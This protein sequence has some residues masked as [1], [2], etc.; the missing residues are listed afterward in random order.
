MGQEGAGPA[1]LAVHPSYTLTLMEGIVER[2]YQD[3][4][5][6]TRS[7]YTAKATYSLRFYREYFNPDKEVEVVKWRTRYRVN[8]EGAEFAINLDNVTRPQGLGSFIEI[9]AR[10]WSASDAEKKASLIS[11][12]LRELG[13]NPENGVRA[14]Y[15]HLAQQATL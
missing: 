3:S 2:E 15:V 1:G 13:L 7:R 11:K 8:Y 10:T 14:E 5:I 9:K 4:V 6:L 12:L